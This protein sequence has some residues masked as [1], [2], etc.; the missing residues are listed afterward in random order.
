MRDTGTSHSKAK[1]HG[2]GQLFPFRLSRVLAIVLLR[3]NILGMKKQLTGARAFIK[4]RFS[5][6]NL[7]V[8]KNERKTV[9][10]T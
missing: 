8:S 7:R 10:L 6:V 1:T 9:L 3:A 5:S 2:I 4:L